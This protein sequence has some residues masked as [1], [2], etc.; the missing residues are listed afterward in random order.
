MTTGGPEE[1]GTMLTAL[2]W[3]M[4]ESGAREE[5]GCVR[6]GRSDTGERGATRREKRRPAGK[7]GRQNLRSGGKQ[8]GPRGLRSGPRFPR[9]G[10]QGRGA[11]GICVAEN[12]GEGRHGVGGRVESPQGAD[13]P[14]V[15]EDPRGDKTPR[16]TTATDVGN[17]LSGHPRPLCGIDPSIVPE[18]RTRIPVT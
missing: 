14:G 18:P 11:R 4:Q 17:K 13:T 2:P 12:P 16:G 6:A 3:G 8:R 1:R 15:A 7:Y 10:G 9:S 5:Q